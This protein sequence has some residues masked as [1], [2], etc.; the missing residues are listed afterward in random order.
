L[1]DTIILKTQDF[2]LLTMAQI[3]KS[4]DKKHFSNSSQGPGQ[5]LVEHL[6]NDQEGMNDEKE[7]KHRDTNK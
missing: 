3:F 1:H 6:S 4:T 2:H 5:I 7:G